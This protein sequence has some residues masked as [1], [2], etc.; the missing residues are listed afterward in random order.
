MTVIILVLVSFLALTVAYAVAA[1][2]R[3]RYRKLF[4]EAVAGWDDSRRV[5][6]EAMEG[7]RKEKDISTAA[8]EE[9]DKALRL[10]SDA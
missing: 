3:N 7:W 6:K 4:N 5:A 10:R 9:L 8:L 2:E 1:L